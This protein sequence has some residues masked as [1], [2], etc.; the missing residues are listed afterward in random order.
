MVEHRQS[1][2]KP[3]DRPIDVLDVITGRPIGRVGNLSVDGMLLIS[4]R[5][6][7][8]NALFQLSFSLPSS[9]GSGSR[10]LEI[11]VNEQWGERASAPGQ[12]WTGF[13]IIDISREDQ[14]RLT[15]WVTSSRG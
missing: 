5:A 10:P 4:Q 2:R 1:V 9:D 13:H 3:P 8:A 14:E 7:P 6:L 11:G 15:A 12:F